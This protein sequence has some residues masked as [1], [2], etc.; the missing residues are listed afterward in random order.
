M[1]P[2]A[3]ALKM[4]QVA[5]QANLISD[6]AGF[7]SKTG[8]E[9]QQL[10]SETDKEITSRTRDMSVLPITGIW[11]IAKELLSDQSG[12][13]IECAVRILVADILLRYAI[14]M[15]E[16]SEIVKRMKRGIL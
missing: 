3:Q 12:D 6:P 13:D 11:S 2:V 10:L 1:L 5:L 9:V 16:N 4:R 14:E 15:C 7:A 8:Q